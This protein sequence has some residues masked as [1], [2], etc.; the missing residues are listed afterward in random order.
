[1]ALLCAV[2][3]RVIKG[4]GIAFSLSVGSTES[5]SLIICRENNVRWVT[6]GFVV[7]GHGRAMVLGGILTEQMI[8]C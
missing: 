2:G 5:Y 3:G 6:A 8:L 1:M 4:K 7:D